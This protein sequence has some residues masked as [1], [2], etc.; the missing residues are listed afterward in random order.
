MLFVTFF[1]KPKGESNTADRKHILLDTISVDEIEGNPVYGKTI[2]GSKDIF[3]ERLT[4]SSVFPEG[5]TELFPEF[6]EAI[7]GEKYQWIDFATIDTEKANLDVVVEEQGRICFIPTMYEVMFSVKGSND[8]GNIYIAYI[9][10]TNQYGECEGQFEFS[11]LIN[12]DRF[13]VN[14]NQTDTIYRFAEDVDHIKLLFYE[15]NGEHEWNF[16]K[17]YMLNYCTKLKLINSV[18]NDYE[19]DKSLSV[20]NFPIQKDIEKIQYIPIECKLK[21]MS[22]PTVNGLF[23]VDP[24]EIKRNTFLLGYIVLSNNNRCIDICLF[25]EATYTNNNIPNDEDIQIIAVFLRV[26]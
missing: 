12:N 10:K 13:K 23:Y 24:Q 3:Y 8:M 21:D 9:P 22:F 25:D 11:Y 16:T 19:Y 5:I 7:Q 17:E 2:Q 4:I 1:N 14:K 20:L 18:S 15:H 26:Y 6:K